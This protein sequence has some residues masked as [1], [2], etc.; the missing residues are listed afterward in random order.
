M[1][2]S[3]YQS[4]WCCIPEDS[5]CN[6]KVHLRA[7]LFPLLHLSLCILYHIF[8]IFPFVWLLPS[9]LFFDTLFILFNIYLHIFCIFK[10]K[11]IQK[12]IQLHPVWTICIP[13]TRAMK[14]FLGRVTSGNINTDVVQSVHICVMCVTNLSVDSVHWTNIYAGTQGSVCLVTCVINH[15][16]HQ[17]SW[18][19]ISAYIVVN[20][21][22]LVL[23]VINL[24]VFGVIW[25]HISAYIVGRGHTSV[26]CVRSP[27]DIWVTW[28]NIKFCTLDSGHIPVIC[29]K[30]RSISWVPWT[31]INVPTLERHHIHV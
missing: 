7:V 6:D 14:N 24:S 17:V 28:K 20:A 22:I 18:I 21:P 23:C 27:F 2:A 30:N 19:Y 3:F 13:V 4:T 1:L 5:N 10:I 12:D 29:V 9:V 11:R 25:L 31:Y 8:C 26:M 16:M 15:F